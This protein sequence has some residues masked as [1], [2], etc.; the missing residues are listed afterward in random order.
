MVLQQEIRDKTNS[1]DISELSK[2]MYLYSVMREKERVG[3]GKVVI[4]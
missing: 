1:I 3:E 2:G 4:E